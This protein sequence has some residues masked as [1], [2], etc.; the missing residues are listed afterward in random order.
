VICDLREFKTDV[1]VSN[2]T[3]VAAS[4]YC[5]GANR[6]LAALHESHSV[7]LIHA[8]S[9]ATLLWVFLRFVGTAASASFRKCLCMCHSFL[10]LNRFTLNMLYLKSYQVVKC[11]IEPFLEGGSYENPREDEVGWDLFLEPDCV[12]NIT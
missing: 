12:T 11:Y 6:R 9:C 10:C 8:F 1:R 7:Y 5:A 3:F 2:E 4:M